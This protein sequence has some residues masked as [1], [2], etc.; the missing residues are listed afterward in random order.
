MCVLE[1][2]EAATDETKVVGLRICMRSKAGTGFVSYIESSSLLP[3]VDVRL[4]SSKS[5]S[6]SI[7]VE[8]PYLVQRWTNA[9]TVSKA[10]KA[11]QRVGSLEAD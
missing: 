9:T 2:W 7:N 11:V 8:K 4:R 6:E 10:E 1:V 3:T 5:K